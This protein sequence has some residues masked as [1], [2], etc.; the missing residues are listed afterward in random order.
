MVSIL[1][2]ET[3]LGSEESV[4]SI[5]K[6]DLFE[7]F[8]K[9]FMKENIFV[10]AVGDLSGT[11]FEDLLE[12]YFGNFCEGNLIFKNDLP[13]YNFNERVIDKENNPASHCDN[14]QGRKEFYTRKLPPFNLYYCSWRQYVVKTLPEIKRRAWVGLHDLCVSCEVRRY[15]KYSYIRFNSSKICK[16]H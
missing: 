5:I 12:K 16:S 8:H 14:S 13:H 3:P 10:S 1:L 4:R 11:Y 7:Y 6:E 15:R 2:Q 9:F